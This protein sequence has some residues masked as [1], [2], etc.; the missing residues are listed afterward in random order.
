MPSWPMPATW[1]DADALSAA[2]VTLYG[3]ELSPPCQK[4]MT[5]LHKFNI[6][7]SSSLRTRLLHP[8]A[9]PVP[10]RISLSPPFF[11][12]PTPGA[13]LMRV[14]MCIPPDRF[15]YVCARCSTNLSRG[16]RRD[17]RTRKYLSWMLGITKSTTPT[18]FRR[19]VLIPQLTFPSRD[20]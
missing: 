20:A 6:Q 8:P 3:S 1:T 9:Q 7:V 19:R 12:L 4:I 14:Y 16:K 18:S 11:Q 5:I 10:P 2:G 13:H 17:L 15:T